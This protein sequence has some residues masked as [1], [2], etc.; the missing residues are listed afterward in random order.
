M[1][2]H[3]TDSKK[4]AVVIPCY[5]E[6]SSIAQVISKFPRD[7]LQQAGIQLQ[8]CVVDNN[9]S[10][11]T[12]AIAKAHGALVIHEPK[13]GKGNALRA[14]FQN[15][16]QDTDYVAMLDGDNTYSPEEVMRLIEPLRSDFCDVVVGSR[17]YGRIQTTAM[18]RLNRLG[19][20]LFTTFV[21]L[22]Y[23]A[24]VTDVLTG[25]FA[26]KKQTLDE[27]EP[28]IKSPGF[29]IEMEMITK[30]ARLGH[31][32]AAVPISYHPRLGQSSLRPFKDGCRI[33]FMLLKN[34]SWRPRR[35]DTQGGSLPVQAHN[36]HQRTFIPR[37]IVF[38]SDAIYPYMKG[39]KE[40]RLHEITT[41]LARMG[42]DVHIYTMHGKQL[43]IDPVFFCPHKTQF[44]GVYPPINLAFITIQCGIHKC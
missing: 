29:A 40:K 16:A 31:R 44:F 42:H 25:Y 35:A 22:L 38:V 11:E 41:R 2:A 12:V 21:R 4:L 36:A 1:K 37:K 39:G 3:S 13:R 27:L 17:L 19:N 20:W 5:N 8:L 14:G 30:M 9:S 43:V 15:I 18:S 33:L 32:M 23:G 6:A 24:N 34:L 26:W 10:D 7:L 28:H